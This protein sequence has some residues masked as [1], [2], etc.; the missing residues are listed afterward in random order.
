MYNSIWRTESV[1]KEFKAIPAVTIPSFMLGGKTNGRKYGV[2]A[3]LKKVS[4]NN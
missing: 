4:V 3:L 1:R 2:I